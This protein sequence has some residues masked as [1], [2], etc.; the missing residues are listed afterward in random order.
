MAELT[1]AVDRFTALLG[2]ERTGNSMRNR[3][4]APLESLCDARNRTKEAEVQRSKGGESQSAGAST[5]YLL[6][7][8]TEEPPREGG[9]RE[10]LTPGDKMRLEGKKYYEPEKFTGE[11]GTWTTWRT[12]WEETVKWSAETA[13][14]ALRLFVKGNAKTYLATIPGLDEKT[15]Q[16]LLDALEGRYGMKRTYDEETR[17]L[18]HRK[19]Q[20]TKTWWGA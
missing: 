18:E 1:R 7:T 11:F 2:E 12:D 4:F 17:I 3:T 9:R 8:P 16:R 5:T 15:H 13:C 6:G 14:R 10:G 19:K 20:P